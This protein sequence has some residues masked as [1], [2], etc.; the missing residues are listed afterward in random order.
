MRDTGEDECEGEPEEMIVLVQVRQ[1]YWCLAGE[2]YLG[3][4]LSGL[5]YYPTPVRCM[6]FET[7][8]DI[9]RSFPEGLPLG[10]LWGINPLII[11][12]LRNQN[13]LVEIEPPV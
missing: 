5:D 10:E 9:L 6:K 13:H 12:R 11:E 8:F 7:E 1:S 4:M 2:K 3:A